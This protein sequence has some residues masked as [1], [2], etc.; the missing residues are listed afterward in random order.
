MTEKLT[1]GQKLK[2][3]CCLDQR[4]TCSFTFD[5][6]NTIANFCYQ[7]SKPM[8]KRINILQTLKSCQANASKLLT[9]TALWKKKLLSCGWKF[10]HTFFRQTI[11]SD[12]FIFKLALHHEVGCQQLLVMKQLKKCYKTFAPDIL[13]SKCTCFIKNQCFFFFV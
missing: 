2:L 7:S 12:D 5:S 4:K 13:L 11:D 3:F 10:L 6:M 8:K 9:A 1:L